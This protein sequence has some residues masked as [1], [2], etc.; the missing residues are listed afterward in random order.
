MQPLHNPVRLGALRLFT[1]NNLSRLS[2]E[3]FLH[4][5]EPQPCDGNPPSVIHEN[6]VKC[7]VAVH[8]VGVNGQAVTFD[9]DAAGR[10]VRRA[11]AATVC[12][13]LW[14]GPALLI[15]H[16]PSLLVTRP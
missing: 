15:Y 2:G 6:Y 12:H 5:I 8:G 13:L 1:Y 3:T 16:A 14:D 9:Y 10:L 11:A 4:P 7:R